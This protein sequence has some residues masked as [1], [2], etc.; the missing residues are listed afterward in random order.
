MA[1][2]REKVVRAALGL[3][4]QVGLDGLTLRRL[5]AEL[6]VQAPAL[7]WH[8]KNKQELL[9]EMATLALAD[10]VREYGLP[11]G[12]EPWEDWTFQYGKSLR[13]TFL[14]YRDGA[15]MISGAYLTDSA[16]FAPMEASL[17]LFQKHGF[18]VAD[19]IQGLGT[20]YCYVVGF[21]IEEQAVYPRPGERSEKY[22]LEKRAARID[23]DKMPLA[24][25]AGEQSLT[26]FDERFERGLRI[27]VRG[28]WELSAL[29]TTAAS[30]SRSE[31]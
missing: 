15:K 19:A 24:R 27:I 4:N 12:S 3:L 11:S 17:R 8:F 7:Y 18:S 1:L 23:A 16:M 26:N 28:M 9:D 31:K 21:T 2:D 6:G 30:E 5:G 14:Q 10:A 13:Q 20:M 29:R 25:G 22:D